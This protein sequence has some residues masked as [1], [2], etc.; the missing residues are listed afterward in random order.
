LGNE[1][2]EKGYRALRPGVDRIA[3]RQKKEEVQGPSDSGHD[4][5]I[6]PNI[7]DRDFTVPGKNQ[8][9]VS[10]MTHIRTGEGW[11]C[12]TVIMDLFHRKVVG[13]SMGKTFGTAEPIIPAWKMAVRSNDNRKRPVFHSDGAPQ[14][15]GYK[16][17]DILLDIMA[18][19]CN[20]WAEKGT[21]GTMQW[22]NPS[23]R[24]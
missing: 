23:S 16:F 14:Y 18:W 7:L 24:A 2:L 22:R 13:W 6:A 9:R 8:V 3:F 5:P 1:A 4:Y 21:V 11:M 12:L 20:Q 10:D 17:T 15:A 19:W